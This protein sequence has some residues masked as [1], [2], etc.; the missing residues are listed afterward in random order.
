[1]ILKKGR[2]MSKTTRALRF[3]YMDLA[4]VNESIFN[5]QPVDSLWRGIH[6]TL[7]VIRD[8]LS[9]NHVPFHPYFSF[10]APNNLV[11]PEKAGLKPDQIPMS[12]KALEVFIHQ[13]AELDIWK[14][15]FCE[16]Y[17]EHSELDSNHRGTD[18]DYCS[19]C[20]SLVDTK[21]RQDRRK[22]VARGDIDPNIE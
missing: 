6:D 1:M 9:K 19:P 18:H 17:F 5:N 4:H 15:D 11:A 14:C 10:T 3:A 20:A 12:P 21:W 16:T 13:A 8:A 2:R 22:A 7:H